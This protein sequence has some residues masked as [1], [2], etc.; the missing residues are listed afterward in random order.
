MRRQAARYTPIPLGGVRMARGVGSLG[1]TLIFLI[2]KILDNAHEQWF[3]TL[4]Y[5]YVYHFLVIYFPGNWDCLVGIHSF[6]L[7]SRHGIRLWLTL[8]FHIL[9]FLIL[10]MYNHSP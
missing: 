1:V 4:C 3:I 7:E 10:T 8:S 5:N 6:D 2:L 9:T